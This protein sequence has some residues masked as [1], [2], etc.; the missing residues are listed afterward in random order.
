MKSLTILGSTGSIGRNTLNIVSRFKDEVPFAAFGK[1]CQCHQTVAA[2]FEEI[3]IAG[4]S[5]LP[6]IESIAA[7]DKQS[8]RP[9]ITLFVEQAESDT[10]FQALRDG[11]GA[12]HR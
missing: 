1:D 7:V 11:I 8:G 5:S 6:G 2:Q 12:H 9:T 3:C 10:A 4:Q